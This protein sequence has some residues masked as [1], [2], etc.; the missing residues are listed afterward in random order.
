[1][2]LEFNTNTLRGLKK[3]LADDDLLG[4]MKIQESLYSV[5]D[6]KAAVQYKIDTSTA[7]L[8]FMKKIGTLSLI[9]TFTIYLLFVRPRYIC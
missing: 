1:M 9:I 2:L 3:P 6:K 7:C 5:D 8:K 4:L